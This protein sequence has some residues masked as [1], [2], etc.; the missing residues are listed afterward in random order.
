MDEFLGSKIRVVKD[1]KKT[2]SKVT[3]DETSN[4][5]RKSMN[6]RLNDKKTTKEFP[7]RL[8]FLISRK[9]RDFIHKVTIVKRRL[10]TKPT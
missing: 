1:N 9:K 2:K 6:P 7:L 8:Q 5:K 3:K 10:M 4:N